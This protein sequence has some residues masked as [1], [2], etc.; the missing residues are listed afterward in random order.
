[1]HENDT[2]NIE[3]PATPTTFEADGH[4]ADPAVTLIESQKGNIQPA[5]GEDLMFDNKVKL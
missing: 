5:S 1:M 4:F 2:F 3:I